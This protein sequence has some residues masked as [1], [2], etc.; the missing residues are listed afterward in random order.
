GRPPPVTL[1]TTLVIG[2]SLGA[3]YAL[4]AAGV[5]VVYQV[6]RVP[7]VAVVAVGTVAAVLHGDLMSPDGRVGSGFGWWPALAVAVVAAAVLGLICEALTRG[8]REQIVPALVALFGLSAVLLAGVNAVWGSEAKFLPPPWA[9]Q[10]QHGEYEV[11]RPPPGR[12]WRGEEFRFGAPHGVDAGEQ[13]GREAEEGDEGGDDLFAQPPGQLVAEKTENGGHADRYR[14]RR[15]PAEA[16]ADP[17]IRSHEV[18][19][20]HGRD[21]ADGHDG[22]VGD[23]DGLVDDRDS[24]GEEGVDGAER[25]ADD[26]RRDQGHRWRPPKGETTV[27]QVALPTIVPPVSCLSGSPWAL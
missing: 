25:Q 11:A 10:F 15:P 27:R 4:L 18:A 1:V 12:R 6:A 9:G 13:E 5:T 2:L 22:H 14:E 7:N 21:G 19:V 23:P 26:Q 17:P 8:L 16:R 24:G 20:E 3:V